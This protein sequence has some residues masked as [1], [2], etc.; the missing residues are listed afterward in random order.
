MIAQ[1]LRDKF[2]QLEITKEDFFWD[3]N[4]SVQNYYRAL[5]TREK[6]MKPTASTERINKY[7]DQ[8]LRCNDIGDYRSIIPAVKPQPLKRGKKSSQNSLTNVKPKNEVL[9]I[10][11]ENNKMI[12]KLLNYYMEE[13]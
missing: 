6:K 8:V 3:F 1:Q 13:K 12:L 2:A 4:V 11:L 5:K 9:E 7:F 10:I